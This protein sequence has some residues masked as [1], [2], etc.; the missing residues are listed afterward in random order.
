[1][2][3]EHGAGSLQKRVVA[4]NRFCLENIYPRSPQPSL[5]KSPC[6]RGGVYDGAARCIHNHGFRAHERNE[7]FVYEVPGLFR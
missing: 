6:K 2:R 3:S 1:M 4:F 7:P 5:L